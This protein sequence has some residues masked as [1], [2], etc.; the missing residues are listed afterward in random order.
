MSEGKEVE[1]HRISQN[2]WCIGKK[3][4]FRGGEKE[5]TSG[6]REKRG[7]VKYSR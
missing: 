3:G 6:Q 1:N 5:E 7:G 2:G 4:H